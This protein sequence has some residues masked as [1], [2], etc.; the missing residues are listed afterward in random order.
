MN[1]EVLSL[2]TGDD[3]N[4][5]EQAAEF[6]MDYVKHD[7]KGAIHGELEDGSYVLLASE[8]IQY[9]QFVGFPKDAED[10]QGDSPR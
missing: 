2:K 9:V 1:G 5:A 7:V 6:L 3:T 4:S 8:K 10:R